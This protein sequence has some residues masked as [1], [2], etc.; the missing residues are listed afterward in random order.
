MSCRETTAKGYGSTAGSSFQF[1]MVLLHQDGR[2]STAEQV[3]G[4][5]NTREPTT[6]AIKQLGKL[7]MLHTDS[8]NSIS[9]TALLQISCYRAASCPH[10]DRL[11]HLFTTVSRAEMT[12]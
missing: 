6:T 8:H 3:R 12:D 9:L 5:I 4:G 1:L 2:K 7:R 10:R 11:K